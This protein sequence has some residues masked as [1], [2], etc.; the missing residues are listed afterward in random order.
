MFYHALTSCLLDC[1]N[2]GS[3]ILNSASTISDPQFGHTHTHIFFGL[4]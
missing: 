4:G 2:N 3:V 1:P